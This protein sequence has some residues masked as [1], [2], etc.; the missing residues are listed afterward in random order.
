MASPGISFASPIRAGTEERW[1]Q[2]LQ[3]LA[4]SRQEEY[5]DLRRRMRITQQR[6]WLMRRRRQAMAVLHLECDEPGTIA[7]RLAA[8]TEP[9]DLWLKAR[10]VEFHGCN[11]TRVPPGWSPELVFGDDDAA[12]RTDEGEKPPTDDRGDGP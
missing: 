8:S 3:E 6:V 2:F 11:F 1:R 9:F 4:G 12:R 7:A 5:A 10:L